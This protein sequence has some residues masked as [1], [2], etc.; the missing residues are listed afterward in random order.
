MH[1]VDAYK[2]AYQR[3]WRTSQTTT[4]GALDRAD[5]RGESAAWYDGYNDYAAG[6]RKWHMLY[7]PRHDNGP[8]GCGLA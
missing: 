5:A 6:R 7:C 8:D 3:G 4:G 2:R 1:A